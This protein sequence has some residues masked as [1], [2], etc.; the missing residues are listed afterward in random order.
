MELL[1][2]D[3]IVVDYKWEGYYLFDEFPIVVGSPHS[4]ISFPITGSLYSA[5]VVSLHA[6]EL[7][8]QEIVSACW[9]LPGWR[10]SLT[11]SNCSNRSYNCSTEMS[12]PLSSR[13]LPSCVGSAHTPT[14]SIITGFTFQQ[15]RKFL[16]P[17]EMSQPVEIDPGTVWLLIR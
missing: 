15:L 13:Q 16:Q 12:D 6:Q 4:H 1:Q 11:L 2:A 7:L 3:E 14:V 9:L 8:Q 5:C 17:Q 10:I